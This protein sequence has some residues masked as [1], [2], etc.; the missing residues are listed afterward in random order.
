MGEGI[1]LQIPQ[2][3]GGNASANLS[4]PGS[5]ASANRHASGPR[6]Q[7]DVKRLLAARGK[8]I[9]AH[10]QYATQ[11]GRE[12]LWIE[13]WDGARSGRLEGL[14]PYYIEICRR[15]RLEA[16]GPDEVA[17][18][19]KPTKATRLAASELRGVTGDPWTPVNI[20]KGSAFTSSDSGFSYS[21][22]QRLLGEE[23]KPGIALEPM[24]GEGDMLFVA[25]VLARGKCETN[26][27]HHRTL[28]IPAR[29]AR[30][31]A[32]DLERKALGALAAERVEQAGTVARSILLPSLLT[33]FQG[34]PAKPRKLDYKDRRA[35]RWLDAFDDAVDAEFFEQLWAAV[36]GPAAERRHQWERRLLELAR[37]QLDHALENAPASSVFRYRAIAG[38]ERVFEGFKRKSFKHLFDSEG[39]RQ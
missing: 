25:E 20:A 14:D 22:I 12:L 33:L 8:V 5:L 6:F 10:R 32:D 13:P 3:R 38:A 4:W 2:V 34:D 9:A 26:G 23:F 31:L 29:V 19:V 1:L 18:R 28:P 24:I 21:V 35:L 36:D 39:A 37:T 27:F 16:R 7:R 30:R 11:G 17:A 15:V